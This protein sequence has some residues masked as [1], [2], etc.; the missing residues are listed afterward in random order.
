MRKFE[1]VLAIG[2]H[3]DDIEIGCGGTIAKW[4]KSG[5]EIYFMVMTF[6]ES[7]GEAAIR[8]QEQEDAS[9][10]L[11]IKKLYWG[12]YPDANFILDNTL[13]TDIEKVIF[14]MSPDVVFV[15]YHKDTH[16]DHRILSTATI[17]A[18]R[19]TSN[20]LFYEGPSSYEFSPVVFVDIS[21]HIIKK[22]DS[23]YAHT[24]QVNK[25]NIKGL[26]I[27]E[28]AEANA[29]FRGT[30]GRVKYAEAFVPFRFFV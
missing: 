5:A 12:D 22:F 3:P 23:L 24:S 27:A 18:S 19:Y 20:V 4:A 29:I 10:I 21:S 13:I 16:Q 15:H 30:E 26:N 11:G 25:T 7:G 1:K 14:E 9:K 2:S 28:I 17:T 8:K 6:G